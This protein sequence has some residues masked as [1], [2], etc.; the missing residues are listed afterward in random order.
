MGESEFQ[1]T[2]VEGEERTLTT[3]WFELSFSGSSQS[4]TERSELKSAPTLDTP[5][6]TWS[7]NKTKGEV[8]AHCIPNSTQFTLQKTGRPSHTTAIAT[9]SGLPSTTG[10][11]NQ[12]SSTVQTHTSFYKINHLYLLVL[13]PHS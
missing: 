7:D 12:Q 6:V 2:R 11:G 4:K 1:C 10:E 13:R 8:K 3:R 5:F 9:S